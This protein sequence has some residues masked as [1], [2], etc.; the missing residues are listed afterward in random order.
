MPFGANMAPGSIIHH[1]V[2]TKPA[3]MFFPVEELLAVLDVLLETILA[4]RDGY[5][6]EF[7]DDVTVGAPAFIAGACIIV[8][9]LGYL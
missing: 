3:I 5:V 8:L 2:G 1:I 4:E 9:K 7:H 6:L